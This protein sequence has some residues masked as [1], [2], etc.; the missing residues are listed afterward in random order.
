M[1]ILMTDFVRSDDTDINKTDRF[2]QSTCFKFKSFHSSD[3]TLTTTRVDIWQYPLH[4]LW[5]GAKA[6]LNQAET[7][8]AERYYFHRHQRRFT[9]ARA[10]LRLILS[11]YLKNTKPHELEFNENSYGKPQLSPSNEDLQFN[12]SHSGD[13]ALLAIGQQHALGIDLEFFAG[14]AYTGIGSHLFSSSENAG[15]N[16]VIPSLKPLSFFHIWAQ[17]EAF[18][19]ACGLGLSYP[20]QQFDVP[21]LPVTDQTV[22]DILHNTSWHITSF[23]PKIGCSAAIC[24]HPTVHDIRYLSLDSHRDLIK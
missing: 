17:K 9:V 18:I 19:K 21:Y 20:T 4:T 6:L 22:H 3:C 15:L 2:S 16:Q 11:R 8:R 24:H 14:R 7:E 1:I 10:M 5:S 12:L 13:L 23:M